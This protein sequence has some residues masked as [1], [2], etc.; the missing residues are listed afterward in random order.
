MAKMDVPMEMKYKPTID[1]DS[2]EMETVKDLKIGDEV[3]V[4]AKGRVKSLREDQDYTTKDGEGKKKIYHACLE[5]SD[6]EMDNISES[7]R[8]KA[9][10]EG[11]EPAAYKKAQAAKARAM[12]ALEEK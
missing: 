12:K 9:E 3:T 8:D 1:I 10:G 5:L 11:M 4:I 2:R 7:D 6:I